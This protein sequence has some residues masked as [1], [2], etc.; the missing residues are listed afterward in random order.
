[1]KSEQARRKAIVTELA[2][3]L[4]YRASEATRQ[5]IKLLDVLIEDTLSDLAHVAPD[6][7]LYTQGALA[8]LTALRR[9]IVDPA[10]H[11]MAKA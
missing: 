1:M 10:Q 4:D 8:Q 2:A 7:L 5:L 9:A 3:L 6:R 11:H